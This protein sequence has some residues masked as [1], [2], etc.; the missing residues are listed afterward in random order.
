MIAPLPIPAAPTAEKVAR[1]IERAA[2]R[3]VEKALVERDRQ[4]RVS[5][6]QVG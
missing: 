5:G 4:L 1:N 6:P 2:Q 3:E